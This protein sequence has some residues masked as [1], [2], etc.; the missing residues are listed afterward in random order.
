MCGSN[1]SCCNGNANRV[2]V[3]FVE[4]YLWLLCRVA[5]PELLNG[6]DNGFL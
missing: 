3:D 4:Y 6:G 1:F 5:K 2:D